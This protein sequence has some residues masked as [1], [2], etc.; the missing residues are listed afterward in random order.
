MAGAGEKDVQLD[1]LAVERS[2]HVA[3]RGLVHPWIRCS[4]GTRMLGRN[5]VRGESS[6]IEQAGR[7]SLAGLRLQGCR[8]LSRRVSRGRTTIAVADRKPKYSQ[9]K[10]LRRC[11][12]GGVFS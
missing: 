6:V 11:K 3:T 4:L 9:A 10:T 5:P 2:H 8:R 7:A 1:A 12:L